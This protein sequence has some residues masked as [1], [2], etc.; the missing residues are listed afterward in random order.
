MSEWIHCQRC[1]TLMEN[2]TACPQCDAVRVEPAPPPDEGSLRD[3]AGAIYKL[4]LVAAEL[5][6]TG[7]ESAEEL[8]AAVRKFKRESQALREAV[9]PNV[10]SLRRWAPECFPL[11]PGETQKH[12][13]RLLM[14]SVA[15]ELAN[16]LAG[17]ACDSARNL[18]SET[19]NPPTTQE[20]P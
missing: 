1:G 2:L 18:P 17:T 20:N 10:A 16:A 11:A 8:R 4:G 9:Q 6:L 7:Q 5:G 12:F 3:I 13:A 15:D 19:T 14:E